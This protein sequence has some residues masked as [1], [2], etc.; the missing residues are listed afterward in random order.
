MIGFCSQSEVLFCEKYVNWYKIRWGIETIFRVTDDIRIY[1]NSNKLYLAYF[2]YNVWKFFQFFLG[3]SFTLANFC[4]N[5]NKFMVER[6]MIN[7]KNHREFVSIFS[8]YNT[9]SK[10]IEKQ[11]E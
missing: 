9:L 2:V 5:L 1:T 4:I 7:P 10:Q 3:E 11:I 8:R 6:K